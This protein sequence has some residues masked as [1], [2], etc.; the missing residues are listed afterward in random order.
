MNGTLAPVLA[1]SLISKGY[2][3]EGYKVVPWH[4]HNMDVN[5]LEACRNYI[6]SIRPDLICHLATGSVLWAEN[7]AKICAA[8]SID[9]LFT[10][11]AMVF[12]AASTGP[13]EVDCPVT[14]TDEYG[15]NKLASEQAILAHWPQTLICRLGWQLDWAI[16]GNN[17]FFALQAM[18]QGNKAI[19]ANV[20]WMPACSFMSDSALVMRQLLAQ[21]AKGIYHLDSNAN[22][23][24][25]FHEIASRIRSRRGK[26]WIILPDNGPSQD[27][28]LIEK[29]LQIPCI[30]KQL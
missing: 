25:S 24:L 17:M 27:Q 2:Q 28:R 22:A 15:L 19:H 30:S 3:K 23:Q 10:S 8:N 11:S 20:N 1:E 21:K 7:I 13:F 14:A 4:R 16:T 9:L 5:D 29:R 18:A 26:D 12:D 6:E